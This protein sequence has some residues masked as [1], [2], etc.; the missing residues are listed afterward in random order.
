MKQVSIVVA[1]V[2]I[3]GCEPVTPQQAAVAEA[4]HPFYD[5]EVYHDDQRAVTC[6]KTLDS[7]GGIACIP[8]W[9]LVNRPETK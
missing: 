5:V 7:R 2:A 3:S 9:M 8:D 1:I 6:W 4:R